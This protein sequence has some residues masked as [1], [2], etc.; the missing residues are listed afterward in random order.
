[1]LAGAVVDY[2]PNYKHPPSSSSSSSSSSAV[3]SS[4]LCLLG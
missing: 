3:V 4:V 1:M 2:L